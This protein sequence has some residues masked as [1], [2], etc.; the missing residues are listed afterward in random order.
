MQPSWRIPF[1]LTAARVVLAPALI[2]L[3]V[4]FPSRIG[5]AIC[6]ILGFLSDVYD[7]V[8]ARRLGVATPALRR[9]D[10]IADT[11]FYLAALGAAWY[12][13]PQDIRQHIAAICVLA[14][15]ELVRYVVDLAKFRRE[16]SYHMWSSKLWGV[17]L[18][19]AFFSLLV[20]GQAG[21]VVALAIYMGIVADT[22]GLAISLILH[23]P[24]IEVPSFVHA[25]RINAARRP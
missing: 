23:E 18:F 22:E 2:G 14:S 4:Y 8:L 15:L 7:G 24:R 20:L 21:P 6:L 12:L 11:I 16:A 1:A 10:S 19:L 3:A 25:L 17:L 9:F 13:H 5:F